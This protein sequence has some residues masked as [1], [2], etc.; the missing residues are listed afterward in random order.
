MN[1]CANKKL[2]RERSIHAK[3]Q[4]GPNRRDSDHA[5]NGGSARDSRRAGINS[6]ECAR[7]PASREHRMDLTRR[8]G[9]TGQLDLTSAESDKRVPAGRRDMNLTGSET[10]QHNTVLPRLEASDCRMG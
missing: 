3:T 5:G 2:G 10:V 7:G 6:A 1:S 8:Q 9:N 4:R